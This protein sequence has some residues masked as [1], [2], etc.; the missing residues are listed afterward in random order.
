MK[1][2]NVLSQRRYRLVASVA[3][4]FMFSLAVLRNLS[5]QPVSWIRALS[6]ARK[7]FLWMS[8]GKISSFST[9][10]IRIR[11][12][13]VFFCGVE[14]IGVET[15]AVDE[16]T[17]F[18]SLGLNACAL[19]RERLLYTCYRPAK[20]DSRTGKFTSKLAS[21]YFQDNH[22]QFSAFNTSISNL[23]KS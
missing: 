4:W 8:C 23:L 12:T 2:S 15:E 13:E 3:F 20:F 22:E 7:C 11:P 17:A 6:F 5:L 1:F 19:F 16:I 21:F 9:N 18:T 10:F 14:A